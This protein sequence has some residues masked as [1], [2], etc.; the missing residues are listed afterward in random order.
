V[1]EEV[2]VTKD[3]IEEMAIADEEIEELVEEL[4]EEVAGVIEN[5]PGSVEYAEINKDDIAVFTPVTRTDDEGN[6]ITKHFKI[7][8]PLDAEE[9]ESAYWN[10]DAL[11]VM[12]IASKK[13]LNMI[14]GYHRQSATM[15]TDAEREAR[16]EKAKTKVDKLGL[17]QRERYEL[18]GLSEEEINKLLE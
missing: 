16:K 7:R 8:I 2:L 5:L 1:T 3:M 6:S 18:A 11:T 15:M 4:P 12:Q 14:R 9:I 17:T 13:I 10:T